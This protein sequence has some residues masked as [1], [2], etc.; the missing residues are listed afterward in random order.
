M[1]ATGWIQQDRSVHRWVPTARLGWCVQQ[2]GELGFFSA[3]ADK[4]GHQSQTNNSATQARRTI[5][6]GVY[7]ACVIRLRVMRK[8]CVRARAKKKNTAHSSC[9]TQHSYNLLK[10]NCLLAVAKACFYQ[11]TIC[12]AWHRFMRTHVSSVILEI[13]IGD[14][15]KFESWYQNRHIFLYKNAKICS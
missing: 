3:T 11:V 5:F 13:I 10:T 6:N 9:C 8:S 4:V 2:Y 14:F 7:S 1:L 15:Q 12:R